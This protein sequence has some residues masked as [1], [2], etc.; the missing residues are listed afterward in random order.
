MPIEEKARQAF[1]LRNTYRTQAR[2]LMADEEM[3]RKLD[4]E[5]PNQTFESILE[6]KMREKNLSHE[7]AIEDIYQT[8]MKSNKKVNKKLGLE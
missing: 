1:E 8:A 4:R 6:K 2:Q 3:R 7:Q 5:N